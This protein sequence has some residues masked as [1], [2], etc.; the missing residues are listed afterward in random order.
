V[1]IVVSI[2]VYDVSL[3]NQSSY[4]IDDV[5]TSKNR[6]VV[7]HKGYIDSAVASCCG[8]DVCVRN[9]T[10]S[11]PFHF[12]EGA[13]QRKGTR[14][15]ATPT[16]MRCVRHRRCPATTRTDFWHW[17]LNPIPLHFS[18]I[19]TQNTKTIASRVI[20]YIIY[21]WLPIYIYW[22]VYLPICIIIQQCNN[23]CLNWGDGRLSGYLTTNRVSK[24]IY[25]F[26]AAHSLY[27][28]RIRRTRVY[29][30]IIGTSSEIEIPRCGG[31]DGVV[32]IACLHC[33]HNNNIIC[34]S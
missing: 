2:V 13:A 6:N 33:T 26:F 15:M 3:E 1:T 20:Y 30:N 21:S 32:I 11:N 8:R 10:R 14:V 34:E 5:R 23:N 9:T 16:I 27:V 31:G 19:Y 18:Y 7:R 29:Y 24:Q 28:Y 12:V 17:R 22:S 4:H 25:N